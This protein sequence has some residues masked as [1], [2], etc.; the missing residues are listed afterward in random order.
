MTAHAAE[1]RLNELTREVARKTLDGTITKSY[2]NTVEA[3][4]EELQTKVRNYKSAL[5][6][7][8]SASPAEFRMSDANPGDFDNFPIFPHSKDSGLA[9]KT[10]SARRR[11]MKS[12]KPKSPR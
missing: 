2:M 1:M 7:A 6:L 12:T 10:V 8:G 4:A 11:C 9:W 3:E 5:R